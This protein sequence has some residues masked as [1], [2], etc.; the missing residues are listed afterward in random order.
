MTN[1][2]YN[3]EPLPINGQWSAVS[4]CLLIS[5]SLEVGRRI[6]VKRRLLLYN[7]IYKVVF[8]VLF[9]LTIPSGPTMQLADTPSPPNQPHYSFTRSYSFLVP[10][11]VGG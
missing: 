4:M 10:L 2:S 3:V 8:T 9:T 11:R 7:V 5:T 1:D 6:I